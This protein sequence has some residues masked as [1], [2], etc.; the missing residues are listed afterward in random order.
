MP[1]KAAVVLIYADDPYM[2][3]I[4]TDEDGVNVVFDS[5][6]EAQSWIDKN[7]EIGWSTSILELG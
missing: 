7:A 3:E 5:K 6:E 4:F 1:K 2:A